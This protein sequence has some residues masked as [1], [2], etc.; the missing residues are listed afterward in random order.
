[1]KKMDNRSIGEDVG[2][3]GL[4]DVAVGML[5]GAATLENTAAVPQSQAQSYHM[6]PQ[7]FGS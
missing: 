7:Q 1:M 4:S 6:I 5:D 3:L 2:K